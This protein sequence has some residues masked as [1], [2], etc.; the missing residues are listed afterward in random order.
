VLS[1]QPPTESSGIVGLRRVVLD[2]GSGIPRVAITSGSI[3]VTVALHRGVVPISHV[4]LQVA[5]EVF[6]LL[7]K[8]IDQ[9]KTD[10]FTS[11][12]RCK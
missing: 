2:S 5:S 1:S 11:V 3:Q 12:L 9:Y 8:A 10:H 7:N 6:E 4:A